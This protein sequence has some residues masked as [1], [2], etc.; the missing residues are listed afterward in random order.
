M[1]SYPPIL[2][3]QYLVSSELGE[4]IISLR[5]AGKT[6][7]FISEKIGVK[8]SVVTYFCKKNK[9]SVPDNLLSYSTRQKS[10]TKR[11]IS[12]CFKKDKPAKS[13]E[14]MSYIDHL[15]KKMK[16]D[17]PGL[18]KEYRLLTRAKTK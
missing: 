6:L 16:N 1:R 15:E 2:K 12:K 10:K 9:I 11:N 3:K 7:A 14:Q 4:K 17:A 18:I 13:K 5:T 8:K